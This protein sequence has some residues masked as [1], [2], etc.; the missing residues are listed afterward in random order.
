[1]SALPNL[2]AVRAKWDAVRTSLWFLPAILGATALPL[3][4]AARHFDTRS[5]SAPAQDQAGWI[6]RGGPDQAREIVATILSAIGTMTSLVFSITM[7]VLTLA[8][9]QFGPRLVRNFMARRQTQ[10]VLGVFVLTILYA[11]LLLSALGQDQQE[12]RFPSVT[13]AVALAALCLGLLVAFIHH[14]ATSIMSESLI[15]AVGSELDEGVAALDEAKTE[16]PAEGELPQ[17]FGQR[18]AFFGTD[19]FGYVQSVEIDQIL[20]AARQ[21]DVV[22]GLDLRAGNFT[23]ANGRAFGIYPADRA[24]PDLVKEIRAAIMLG[25]HR[26]PIQDLEFPIRHLVEIAVRALS[27]GIN[28]PY[29]AVSVIH[30]LS[31]AWPELMR[32]AVPTGIYHDADGI[33]RLIGPSIDNAS[34]MNA[35]F[36]QIRQAG[37]SMPLVLIHLLKSF[38]S[39]APC[40]RNAAQRDALAAEITAVVED[41]RRE[42]A[43]RADLR[44]VESHAERAWRA[45]ERENPDPSTADE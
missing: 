4:Y 14:L 24:Y 29:T 33:L 17:D 8:A 1:M 20:K 39:M 42:I 7:V 21:A 2:H 11:L 28:D 26:T 30:R 40:T 18:A 32:R 13:V 23:I 10:L 34:L 6:Y 45:L 16:E 37:A 44:D 43:N 31:A 41:A 12:G 25:P 36:S 3:V 22:I 9:G 38:R 27:P 19:G 35:A 15:E 5:G